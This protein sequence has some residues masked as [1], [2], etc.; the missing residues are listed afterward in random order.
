[1]IFVYSFVI[2]GLLCVVGQLLLDVFNV[3]PGKIIVGFICAGAVLALFDWFVPIK[4]FAPAGISVPIIGF[5]ASLAEGA[6]E[7]AR[8]GNILGI[9]AGGLAAT[10][11]GIG[12]AIVIGY[13]C[14][15]IAKPKEK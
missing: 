5:G 9:F 2:G 13:L 11:A 3:E 14:G 10:A 7:E 6:M 4:D 8:N 12:F 15:L 1:M